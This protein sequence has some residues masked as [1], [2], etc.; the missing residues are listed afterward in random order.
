MCVKRTGFVVG[1]RCGS[2]VRGR[3]PE[4]E[5]LGLTQR[6]HERGLRLRCDEVADDL[7][8]DRVVTLAQRD[9]HIHP[10]DG[11]LP[12]PAARFEPSLS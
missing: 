9:A 12:G 5:T 7:R 1:S 11:R 8:R 6:G 10:R 3:Q 4:F 2:P